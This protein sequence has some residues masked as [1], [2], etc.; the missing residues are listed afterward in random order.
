MLPPKVAWLIFMLSIS[1]STKSKART[2]ME[3]R[4]LLAFRHTSRW[5]QCLGWFTIEGSSAT[6]RPLHPER[7]YPTL[8]AGDAKPLISVLIQK[9]K[10]AAAV[11]F[12]YVGHGCK[13]ERCGSVY[14]QCGEAARLRRWTWVTYVRDILSIL[15]R[16]IDAD[17]QP[18]LSFC[19]NRSCMATYVLRGVGWSVS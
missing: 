6:H 11:D 15:G 12:Q 13:D 16:G 5:V 4:Y 2:A 9:A 14:E 10:N 3:N 7:P 18:Q 19:R 17:H 8:H 1:I